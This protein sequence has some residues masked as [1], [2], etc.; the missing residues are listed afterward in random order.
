MSI[1]R[2]RAPCPVALPVLDQTE[3][4]I[5]PELLRQVYRDFSPLPLGS[6]IRA[7][8]RQCLHPIETP[9]H[10]RVP[11]SSVPKLARQ[12][13]SLLLPALPPSFPSTNIYLTSVSLGKAERSQ[14]V[15]GPPPP[16]RQF[17]GPFVCDPAGHLGSHSLALWT[18]RCPSGQAS[19]GHLV[20]SHL[21]S[22]QVSTVVRLCLVLH[23]ITPTTP[24]D[25]YD[26]LPDTPL[27]RDLKSPTRSESHT[28]NGAAGLSPAAP[29]WA[30][31]WL[32]GRGTAG[33]RDLFLESRRPGD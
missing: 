3:A 14:E 5:H 31:C 30:P 15:P 18:F 17:P 1:P 20:L 4:S 7:Q 29:S 33:R 21:P 12:P 10:F 9:G 11:S 16:L 26:Y 19:P 8:A 6:L 25:R 32:L 22:A 28:A 2:L 23:V 24:G 27:M 13:T